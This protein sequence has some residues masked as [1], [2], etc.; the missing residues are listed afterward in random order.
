M[1]LFLMQA[2]YLVTQLVEMVKEEE[3]KVL[4]STCSEHYNK[5]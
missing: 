3:K 5:L 2:C 4:V 1:L